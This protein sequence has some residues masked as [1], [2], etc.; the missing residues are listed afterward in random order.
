[1]VNATESLVQLRVKQQV[2][3]DTRKTE[4]HGSTWWKARGQAVY[5][6]ELVQISLVNPTDTTSAVT[7]CAEHPVNKPAIFDI[8][9][10][11]CES[12]R[13]H[14]TKLGASLARCAQ[15]KSANSR[16]ACS[17]DDSSGNY[18]N[19][20]ETLSKPIVFSMLL[21]HLAHLSQ[22]EGSPHGLSSVFTHSVAVRG[23]QISTGET[24]ES[25]Q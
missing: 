9:M 18:K 24:A 6:L 23:E 13:G 16:Q 19:L 12:C 1:M 22:E 4:V 20:W 10:Q 11:R 8:M 15:G 21:Q 5:S 3:I 14:N 17:Q 7:S 25:R 2:L